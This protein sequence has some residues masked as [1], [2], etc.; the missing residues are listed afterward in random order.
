MTALLASVRSEQE[1]FAAAQAGAELIDLK[2]PRTGALGALP[3]S[4]IGRIAAALRAQ[5]PVKPISATIGDVQTEDV[6][7]IV[8][9]TIDVAGTGVDYVK[10]GI[11]PGP[12]ARRCLDALASLPA[13]VVPVVLCDAG[14]DTELVEHAASLGFV[15]LMFDTAGKDGHTLFDHVDAATLDRCLARARKQ[16]TMCGIAGSLGWAQLDRIRAL[17]PDIAGFR[18][19]LCVD[20]RGSA[21]DPARVA[22]W[23]EA[24]HTSAGT[25]ADGGR[26]A[27]SRPAARP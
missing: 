23:A 24:L 25:S 22:Q 1:A 20:G 11:A 17:A 18:G 13:A 4:Q 21:L 3:V 12:Q 26:D 16:G 9:R 5:Y 15:G 8:A 2:E 6:D 19:A 27:L 14:L 7:E 10:V